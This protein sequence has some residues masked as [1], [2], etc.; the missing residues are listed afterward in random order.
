MPLW[1]PTVVLSGTMGHKVPMYGALP[2]YPPVVLT[3][4]VPCP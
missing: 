2:V 3:H 4:E 1:G